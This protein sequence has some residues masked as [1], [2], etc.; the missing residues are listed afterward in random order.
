MLFTAIRVQEVLPCLGVGL[1]AGAVA[2]WLVARA[3]AGRSAKLQGEIRRSKRQLQAIFDGITDGLIIVDREFRIVAVN[4]AEASFLGREPQDLVGR[5]CY[6]VYCRGDEP[7]ELCPAHET[8]AKGNVALVSKPELAGGYHRKGVD[9][10]TFPVVDEHGTTVQAIQYIK[11]ITDRMKLQK[12]LREVEQLTGIGHMA[13]N[14]AHEIRNP[15]IAVG[16]FARR[17]HEQLTEDDPRREFTEVILEEVTRLEQI[18]R[19]QLTLEKHLVPVM[20]PV[21]INQILKDVRKLLSH[22]ILS[23]HISV[24]G[25][26]AEGL[27]ITMGDA[28]QLKQAFLN[29]TSNAIQSMPQ[30]GRLTIAT[31]QRGEWIVVRIS[32][33][34]PGIAPEHLDKLFVPFFTTRA[35]GSG[36]GLAVTKRIVDNHGGEITVES[37]EGEGSAFEISLPIMHST[38]EFEHRKLYGRTG[39]DGGR[40]DGAEGTGGPG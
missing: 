15:L 19:E 22:G 4:K 18:L 17:L 12:Q 35:A 26:L 9:V 1:A 25:D 33:T 24:V 11:D 27:P 31:L 6:E 16:G 8:F 21:D 14:V 23:S 30:G 37:R 34:G 38:Q 28:N 13:A 5:P 2:G 39:A 40:T 32:D 20:G 10:Y 3:A 29:V 7:C 36:L